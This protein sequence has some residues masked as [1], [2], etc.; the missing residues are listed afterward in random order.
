MVQPLTG[1][2]RALA[3]VGCGAV[4]E[5]VY[6][7]ALEALGAE[8]WRLLFVDAHEARAQQLAAR[9]AGAEAL[10]AIPGAG[11]ITHAIVAT[12]PATHF[13][14]C[15]QLIEAGVHIL[16]EK[17]FVLDPA[18]GTEL[19]ARAE[20][21][22]LKLHV[23]QTRRWY[24]ASVVVKRLLREKVIGEL[25]SIVG[26]DGIRFNWPAKTAFHAQPGLVR[27]GILSDQGSHAFDLIG[28]ILD[29]ALTPVAVEH[30][31]YAG[32]ETTAHIDFTAGQVTG[33][34]V[35]T[36]LLAVPGR[37]RF[38]GTGG[39]L[40]I[41]ENCNRA[42][43]QR[44]GVVTEVPGERNYFSYSELVAAVVDAFVRGG[45][46]PSVATARS[47][48]PSIAFLDQAYR[49]GTATLPLATAIGANSK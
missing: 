35:M 29:S 10:D 34:I 7:P 17:P 2:V 44:D 16:C 22:S 1:S 3:I 40:I 30:D 46:S 36:W 13:K 8:G 42:L 49:M 37:L 19:A 18:E 20:R 48:L 5:E 4:I 47:V 27:N 31:G 11:Q 32:P 21:R 23:N 24:P 26:R 39:E 12:P 28:W 41:D 15:A 33:N 43:L 45:D 9:F 38:I 14:I 6:V 25:T